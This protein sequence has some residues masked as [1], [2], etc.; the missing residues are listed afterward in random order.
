MA[1]VIR[2]P[3]RLA[4]AVLNEGI[5]KIAFIGLSHIGFAIAANIVRRRFDL[6]VWNR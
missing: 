2:S 6:T 3:R 4:H 5:V 1:V